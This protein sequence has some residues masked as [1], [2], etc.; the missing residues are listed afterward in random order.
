MPVS[1]PAN[2]TIRQS[3][4]LLEW[5]MLLTLSVL[6]GGSF[7][8]VGVAVAELPTFTI[9]VL[10]V[11]LA[12]IALWAIVLVLGFPLPR[13]RLLWGSFFVMGLLNNA[14]PFVLI[15]WGQQTIGSGLASIL[16]ATTP[17]F[18][19]VVAGFLLADEK[20][21]PAKLM[22]VV[23]GFL[24]VVVLIGPGVALSL[25]ADATAQLAVLGAALSYAF[26][27]VY[28]R[29]FKRMG[30]DPVVAAAG[31]VSASAL[32]LAPVALFVDQPWRLTPPSASVWGAIAAV[33]ILS[34]ALA[35]I[36]YFKLLARAGATNLLLVTFL[37]PVTA[38]LLGVFVLHE[39][40]TTTQLFGM[41]F[42]GL[43]LVAIDGRLVKRVRG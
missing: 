10:R 19:I 30:V 37:I 32:L 9:V 23:A 42:I 13:G 17:L 25:A 20:F 4:S 24:G 43:G 36:L 18:T 6:W 2:S 21:S 26:A 15:V 1:N 11:G 34:T 8:F 5:A 39:T 28:G 40:L 33:A 7:F 3:M 12:A 35:Y 38:I 16:N 29:R 14:A 27:G 41:A 31:Q 22:G